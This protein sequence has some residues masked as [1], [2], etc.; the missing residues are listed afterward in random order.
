MKNVPPISIIVVIAENYAIGKNNQLLWHISDDLKRFKK[1]TSG[2]KVIMGKKTFQ[3]LPKGPLPNRMNIV[4]SDD[5]NDQ[6]KD[7]EMAYSIQEAIDKCD[8]DKENF[9]IGGGSIY[10]QFLPFAGKLY[11]TKVNKTFE[12]A[13]TFFP[14]IDPSEWLIIERQDNMMD[15]KN[16]FT[17]EYITYERRK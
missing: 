17:W 7:C 13:D 15:E 8:R 3:S 12:G 16:A 14:E 5:H 11:I 6:F 9:I 10:K 1:I 2:H 4:I